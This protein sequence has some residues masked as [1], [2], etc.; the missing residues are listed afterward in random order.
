MLLLL[1]LLQTWANG[2]VPAAVR[3]CQSAQSLSQDSSTP[4]VCG[5][6]F[7]C[8]WVSCRACTSPRPEIWKGGWPRTARLAMS[9]ALHH[10]YTCSFSSLIERTNG[11]QQSR[12]AVSICVPLTGDNHL[13]EGLPF[14]MASSSYFKNTAN[15]RSWDSACSIR[16]ETAHRG[17]PMYEGL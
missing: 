12:Y 17:S 5:S 3:L 7:Q 9:Q 15:A 10:F 8:R 6:Y 4:S 1:G 2:K 11:S 14:D 13:S 16:G